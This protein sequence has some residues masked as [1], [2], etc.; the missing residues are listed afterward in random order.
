MPLFTLKPKNPEKPIYRLRA[1]SLKVY[2]ETHMPG[3]AIK[4]PAKNFAPGTAKR[5][6]LP[7]PHFIPFSPRRNYPQNILLSNNYLLFRR[8]LPPSSNTITLAIKGIIAILSTAVRFRRTCVKI[9]MRIVDFHTTAP[10]QMEKKK[11]QKT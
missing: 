6:S 10:A 11:A 8:M 2:M 7:T 4:L 1:K 5:S 9:G 3:Y